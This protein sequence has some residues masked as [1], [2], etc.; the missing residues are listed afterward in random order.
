MNAIEKAQHRTNIPI[1]VAKRRNDIR[2]PRGPREEGLEPAPAGRHRTIQLSLRRQLR[3]RRH[4]DG[5]ALHPREPLEHA[6]R[7]GRFRRRRRAQR[8]PVRQG[9]VADAAEQLGLPA[10]VLFLRCRDGLAAPRR[11]VQDVEV[12][13]KGAKRDADAGGGREAQPR[14][15][16]GVGAGLVAYVHEDREGRVD[17]ER[18]VRT[19]HLV[20]VVFPVFAFSLWGQ[21]AD[22]RDVLGH[23]LVP[24]HGPELA[25]ELHKGGGRRHGGKLHSL[26]CSHVQRFP[27]MANSYCILAKIRW[28]MLKLMRIT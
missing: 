11:Y 16:Q 21:D 13:P 9:D 22:L 25:G 24:Y 18:L 2:L 4:H 17:G 10:G 14:V 28:T 26:S 20:V 12:G 8:P 27:V 6:R 15:P 5:D 3:R 1:D 7:R 23:G 19:A